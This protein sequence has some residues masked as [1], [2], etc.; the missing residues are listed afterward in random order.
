MLHR[1]VQVHLTGALPLLGVQ[2]NA[3]SLVNLTMVS[4]HL[5]F[6]SRISLSGPETACQRCGHTVENP[7]LSRPPCTI[8][9]LSRAWYHIAVQAVGIAVEFCAHIVHAFL[10]APGSRQLRSAAALASVG[11]AVMSG[12]ALTKLVGGLASVC[13][14]STTTCPYEKLTPEPVIACAFL[15]H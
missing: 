9:P 13:L 4:L 2:L 6:D 11:A 7:Q 8:F 3:V 10:G 5:A 15:L 12:I 14:S 1:Y